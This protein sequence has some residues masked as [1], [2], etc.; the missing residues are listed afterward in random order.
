MVL[1]AALLPPP[2]PQMAG[3]PLP[4]QLQLQAGP[5]TQAPGLPRFYVKSGP[6][7][8]LDTSSF[9]FFS[10][11]FGLHVLVALRLVC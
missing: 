8:E 1:R 7:T 10:S 4:L 5:A 11:C 2:P 6:R 3:F 9:Q